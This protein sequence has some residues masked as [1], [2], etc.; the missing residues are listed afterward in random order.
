MI[1]NYSEP[2]NKD[3]IPFNTV[4]VVRIKVDNFCNHFSFEGH[5]FQAF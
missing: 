5:S 1:R 3:C 2:E 4:E